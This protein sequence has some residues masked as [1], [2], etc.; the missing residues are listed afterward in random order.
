MLVDWAA[1]SWEAFATLLTGAL[2]VGAAIWVGRRQFQIM[3]RQIEISSKQT[4]ILERQSGLDELALRADLFDRRWAVYDATSRYVQI[5]M[6]GGRAPTR[7]ENAA[8]REAIAQAKYLFSPAAFDRISEIAVK[9]GE[10]GHVQERL[11]RLVA[12]LRPGTNP[13]EKWL[14]EMRFLEDQKRYLVSY[15]MD[16]PH[17]LPHMFGDELRLTDKN[18]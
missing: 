3:N 18:G 10:L 6:D 8:Y 7:D 12:Q 9:M 5:V 14:A 17:Q 16:A 15:M 1:F 2:A 11:A 4:E 13:D